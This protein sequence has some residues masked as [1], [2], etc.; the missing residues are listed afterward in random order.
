MVTTLN[1]CNLR[2][3]VLARDGSKVRQLAPGVHSLDG[4][5]WVWHDSVAY[6]FLGPARIG[7]AG[8][9]QRGDWRWISHRYT[10]DEVAREMFT[11]WIEH[12]SAPGNASYAY[13][14]VPGVERASVETYAAE[15]PL[16]ILANRAGLQAV[17]HENL[18]ILGAAFY[19]PGRLEIRPALA[20]AVDKPCLLL[21]GE[22]PEGLVVSVSNPRNEEATVSVEVSG[23][24]GGEDV[25]P[26]GDRERSRVTFQLPSG[27]DAGRSVTKTLT[28]P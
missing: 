17:W 19:E 25:E 28:R 15:P 14:V 11:A 23:R 18:E 10:K 8:E 3:S 22:R 2:G 21:L 27:T 26:S 5:A 20:V 12:G 9:L 1:Q 24:W 7:L 16:E 4:P 13:V 6:V